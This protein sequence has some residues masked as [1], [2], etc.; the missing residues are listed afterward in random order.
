MSGQKGGVQTK[1][2]QIYPYAK[3]THCMAHKLNLVIVDTCKYLKDLRKLFNGLEAIYVHF[4]YPSKNKK[5]NEIQNQLGL[6]K[7]SLVQLSE[8]RWACR[9]KSC[10]SVIQNY[11]V[12]IQSLKEEID[13][14]KNKD[15]AEAIGII[16][17]IKSDYFVVHLFIL[18]NPR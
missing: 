17:T 3:Y 6:K 4:S 10:S 14:Q 8:T 18:D 9:F 2:K 16:S 12:L 15:V 1:L 13:A 5:F 7:T 11:G